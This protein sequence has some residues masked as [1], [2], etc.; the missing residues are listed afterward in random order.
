MYDQRDDAATTISM[1]KSYSPQQIHAWGVLGTFSV[2]TIIRQ[3]E[4]LPGV[5]KVAKPV[6]S[7]RSANCPHR[8]ILIPASVLKKYMQDRTNSQ[9]SRE[10]AGE[11][12][13]QQ[14]TAV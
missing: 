11:T 2:R 8:K 5:I 9:V 3:F 1:E 4:N 7:N 14:G 10:R 6:G 13:Q 12:H